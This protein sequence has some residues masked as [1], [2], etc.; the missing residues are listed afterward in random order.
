MSQ[1][2]IVR[3]A[4]PSNAA[5]AP[6]RLCLTL[7]LFCAAA[8]ATSA[9]QAQTVESA[10]PVECNGK[11]HALRLVSVQAPTGAEGAK[12]LGVVL[13][14]GN[15]AEGKLFFLYWINAQS[16]VPDY[17]DNTGGQLGGNWMRY[18]DGKTGKGEEVV[19]SFFSEAKCQSEQTNKVAETLDDPAA[20]PANFKEV[21]QRLKDRGVSVNPRQIKEVSAEGLNLPDAMQSA[22]PLY[23]VTRKYAQEVLTSERPPADPDQFKLSWE[24]ER[25]GL[26]DQI[27]HLAGRMAVLD[28]EKD[29]FFGGAPYWL[30]IAFSATSAVTLAVVA[31]VGW[32]AYVPLRKLSSGKRPDGSGAEAGTSD[33]QS[34]RISDDLAAII[35]DAQDRHTAISKRYPEASRTVGGSHRQEKDPDDLAEKIHNGLKKFLHGEKYNE[36]K[37]I[38]RAELQKARGTTGA[39]EQLA[40][41]LGA[42]YT[43]LQGRLEALRK[44]LSGDGGETHANIVNP[45]PPEGPPLMIASTWSLGGTLDQLA[46]DVAAVRVGV[47]CCDVK[48]GGLSQLAK[49]VAA[50]K[51]HVEGSESKLAEY[52]KADRGLKAIGTRWYGPNYTGGGAEELIREV[53]EVIDLYQLLSKRCCHEVPSVA[54]TKHCLLD[55]LNTLNE[56]RDTYLKDSPG[57]AG[58]PHRVAANVKLKLSDDAS[59]TNEYRRMEE[60]LRT[61]FG[62]ETKASQAVAK[63]IDERSAVREKLGKY[64]PGLEFIQTVNAVAATYNA[65]KEEVRRAL[66]EV[67]ETLPKAVASLATGYLA[68]KPASDRAAALEAE[69]G[70]LRNRL[71]AALT[72]S[73]AGK[74]LAAEIARQLNF[75]ADGSADA[76]ASVAGALGL[77]KK[78]REEGVYLQLRLGLSSAL[79]ALDKATGEGGSVE[80][81]DVV[82]ALLLEKVNRGIRELLAGMEGYSEEQLW[83]TGIFQGFDD[84]WLH[85]LIRADLLLRTYYADRKEF[86][87][88]RKAVSM[89]CAAL[90]SA[91]YEFHVE[92]VEVGLFGELPR[93]MEKASVYPGV[94]GLTAVREKVLSKIQGTG[95][96]EVV[97][98]VTSFPYLVKGVQANRGCASLANPSAWVQH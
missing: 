44:T 52:F 30:L 38:I 8:A 95:V 23:T 9:Q 61:L 34:P 45:P 74:E 58:L 36:A 73:T 32:S 13:T 7:A 18:G 93:D 90:L 2:P 10:Q 3:T 60:S 49:D 20:I 11:P 94:R 16:S 29:S 81:R 68:L 67:G 98:D 15:A 5:S 59:L 62:A 55:T 27:V 66:P 72:E 1:S 42:A 21:V 89:A 88:L 57:E 41:E 47:D 31:F 24:A 4:P 46:K 69:V 40:G 26:L 56:I 19:K 17:R 12:A 14:T 80:Q 76:P 75:K 70:D 64:H 77:L 51:S 79:M 37:K 50:V 39:Y 25:K 63:L 97:I 86:G 87:P 85:Y 33:G 92:V 91:L 65:I 6:L 96:N 78:E 22:T 54:R 35:Y 84:K 48:L 71:A 28:Q 82:E 43:D 53:G 83:N